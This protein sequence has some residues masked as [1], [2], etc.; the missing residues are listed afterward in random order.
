MQVECIDLTKEKGGRWLF[1]RGNKGYKGPTSR[2]KGGKGDEDGYE[3]E[4]R[5]DEDG[6]PRMGARIRAGEAWCSVMDTVTGSVKLHKLK[7][8]DEAFIDS[9]TLVGNTKPSQLQI[10]K[11]RE[12]LS[13]SQLHPPRQGWDG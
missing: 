7:G 6:L 8:T 10:V 13:L 4:D 11:V 12:N 3:H 9:V 1:G 5:I 2:W